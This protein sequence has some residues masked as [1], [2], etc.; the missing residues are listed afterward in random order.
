MDV[1]HPEVETFFC[2]YRR[3]TGGIM[4]GDRPHAKACLVLLLVEEVPRNVDGGSK[5]RRL[6]RLHR[7]TRD[8]KE[9]M[10]VEPEL[11]VDQRGDVRS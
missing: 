11:D 4:V 1:N 3:C 10:L 5:R 2:G 7:R 6:W 8:R 9:V